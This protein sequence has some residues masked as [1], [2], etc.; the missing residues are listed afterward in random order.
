M[1]VE[2]HGDHK[3]VIMLRLIWP[4]SVLGIL[5]DLKQWCLFVVEVNASGQSY[6]LHEIQLTQKK[7]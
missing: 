1:S 5:S 2:F 6:D 3:T 4:P 7:L